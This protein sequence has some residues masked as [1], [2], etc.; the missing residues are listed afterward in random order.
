MSKAKDHNMKDEIKVIKVEQDFKVCPICGYQDGFHSVFDRINEGTEYG[1]IL[2]C[3]SCHT[4]FD[5]GL[6]TYINS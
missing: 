1:W 2:I 4:T 5:I 3:P 6:R